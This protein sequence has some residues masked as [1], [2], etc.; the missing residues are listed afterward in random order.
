LQNI[1]QFRTI[2]TAFFDVW[3]C[4]LFPSAENLSAEKMAEVSVGLLTHHTDSLTENFG[5]GRICRQAKIEYASD[6][7]MKARIFQTPD[8]CLLAYRSSQ[9]SWFPF[10]GTNIRI[11]EFLYKWAPL[12]G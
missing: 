9:S 5:V 8:Q 6:G 11:F 12:I 3:R 2:G 7:R 4:E 1:G 10:S